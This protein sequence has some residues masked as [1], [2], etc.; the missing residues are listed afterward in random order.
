M[1]NCQDFTLFDQVQISLKGGTYYIIGRGVSINRCFLFNATM[2][3][4]TEDIKIIFSA[5][6]NKSKFFGSFIVKLDLSFQNLFQGKI[7]T[8][9]LILLYALRRDSVS[10]QE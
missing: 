7:S 6:R 9:T 5:S 10:V 4:C 1:L 2:A 8:Q 3:Y